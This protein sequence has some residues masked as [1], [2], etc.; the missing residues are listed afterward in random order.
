M[1][2]GP[3]MLSKNYDGLQNDLDKMDGS[4]PEKRNNIH[5]PLDKERI[6]HFVPMVKAGDKVVASAWL[7]QV[8]ENFQPLKNYGSV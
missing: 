8:D 1:T 7:G 5:N 2:L 4:F 3:G 6:W